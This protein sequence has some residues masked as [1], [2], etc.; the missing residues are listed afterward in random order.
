MCLTKVFDNYKNVPDTKQ[1]IQCNPFGCLLIWPM[2]QAG[3]SVPRSADSKTTLLVSLL[4]KEHQHFPS[5]PL[6]EY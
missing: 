5:K 4:R 1:D 6:L 3:D 2:W